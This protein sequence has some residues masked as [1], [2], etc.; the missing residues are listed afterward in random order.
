MRI[1]STIFFLLALTM[2]VGCSS[3]ADSGANKSA[4]KAPATASSTASKAAT[5]AEN[6]GKDISLHPKLE[7]ALM[8][9][10]KIEYVFYKPGYTFTTEAEGAAVRNYFYFISPERFAKRKCKYEGGAVF[11]ANDDSIKMEVDFVLDE[12]CRHMRVRLDG[13]TYYQQMTDKGFQTLMQFYSINPNQGTPNP[14]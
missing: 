1:L 12:N 10:Y 9:C 7:K 11:R 6:L 5:P 14:K 4:A 13:E 8:D 2:T 3:G